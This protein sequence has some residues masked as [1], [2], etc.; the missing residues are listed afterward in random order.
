MKMQ[1]VLSFDVEDSFEEKFKET[2]ASTPQLA[3]DLVRV[4]GQALVLGFRMSEKD[5]LKILGFSFKKIEE[6]PVEIEKKV[7]N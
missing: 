6:V 7:D 2:Q 1:L 3:L 4:I 5:N